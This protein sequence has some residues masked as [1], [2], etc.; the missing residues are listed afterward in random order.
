[1][2]QL[3]ESGPGLVKPSETLV[4]TCAVSGGGDSFGFH[5]W[6]WIRQPPGKGLE[7]IGHIGG[8]S[9]STD[10]NPSL[11]S[12]VTISMDSSR[13]QFSLRLKSV[14]AADTAVYFCARKGEDFYEDDYGQY[15][16]AGWF[17][18]LW[19]PGTPIIISS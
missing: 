8:S 15:F 9:G 17:F 5:Y 1:Q 11:K 3:R 16:T 10:F 7:W 13:N 4:L 12:R 2:V 19:G 6:N 18:D 14:T